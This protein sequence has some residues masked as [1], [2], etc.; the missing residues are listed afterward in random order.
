MRER[1]S[2]RTRIIISDCQQ[3]DYHC[4]RGVLDVTES[5]WYTLFGPTS[6]AGSNLLAVLHSV[7]HVKLEF[8]ALLGVL[9]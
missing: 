8:L 7:L 5:N 4:R 1:E 2:V 3:F 9:E 6:R